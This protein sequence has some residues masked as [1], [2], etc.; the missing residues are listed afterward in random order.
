MTNNFFKLIEELQQHLSWLNQIL[1]GTQSEDVIIDGEVKP[2]ISKALNGKKEE[3]DALLSQAETA[4]DAAQLASGVYASV[5]AGLAATS[6]SAYFNVPS[7][8]AAENLILYRNDNGSAQ[9]IKRYPSEGA[10][11]DLRR[12]DIGFCTGNN[13]NDG[14][15][16]FDFVNLVITVEASRVF[17][18]NKTGEW[19]PAA[20]I[21]IDSTDR[22]LYYNA[23]TKE[24]ETYP[25]NVPFG[26][27]TEQHALLA[28]FRPEGGVS[29][30][31][32]PNYRVNRMPTDSSG[33][34]ANLVRNAPMGTSNNLSYIDFD[35][36]NNKVLIIG[37]VY[38][39]TQGFGYFA[40]PEG[41]IEF[42]S[43]ARYLYYNRTINEVIATSGSASWYD[44]DLYLLAQFWPN[45]KKVNYCGLS[46]YRINGVLQSLS[47]IEANQI[48]L[49]T[50]GGAGN[51]NTRYL[52]I[53][54][55]NSRI[56]VIGTLFVYLESYSLKSLSGFSVAFDSDTRHIY[57]DR[58]AHELVAQSY[59][60]ADEYVSSHCYLILSFYP[61]GNASAI[62]YSGDA[63]Y[64]VN[65]V[66]PRPAGQVTT[67]LNLHD[68]VEGQKA[69]S[70]RR[71]VP[72]LDLYAGSG[73]NYQNK[74]SFISSDQ[75]HYA[76]EGYAHI[77]AMTTDFIRRNA[78][79]GEL[80]GKT[81][82]VFGGSFSVISASRACKDVWAS[83]L[84]IAY[85]DYGVSGAGFGK[86]NNLIDSQIDQAGVHDIYVLWCST[87]D[88]TGAVAIGEPD[89]GDNTTQN[90]GMNVCIDKL[91]ALNPTAKILILGSL[92]A[93][94]SKY[95]YDPAV[96]R[97]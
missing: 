41:E 10:V 64:R 79:A 15:I 14:G 13:T 95:L 68:Y 42:D 88:C 86:Q 81:V 97:G 89:A 82:G 71:S 36:D 26:T 9:E 5:A 75:L 57:Y 85:T 1:K 53:D 27:V 52:N 44:D 62:W 67:W 65:G 84:G 32:W 31:G 4:R 33:K 60:V 45:H 69:V 83:E 94:S 55:V 29:W 93:Y 74:D 77:A 43:S 73:L 16:I 28:V 96:V 23:G 92:K 46:N 24:Y 61:A 22:H 8:S 3:M 37:G 2:T 91:I 72:Y 80:A 47:A 49:A 66:R 11:Q 58:I 76:A 7:S 21:V 63:G 56:E 35:F 6:P 40:L 51:S 59:R 87:N 12:Y 25:A 54:T 19:L 30:C 18:Q 39:Y 90:G 20:T 34:R 78:P 38:L 48:R 50:L 17:L 70:L